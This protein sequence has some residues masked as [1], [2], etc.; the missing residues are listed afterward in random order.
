[1]AGASSIAAYG[2]EN[3]AQR[4]GSFAVQSV[5]AARAAAQRFATAGACFGQ[6]SRTR[7]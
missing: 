4:G 1:M 7:V 6:R 2:S 3:V 5:T